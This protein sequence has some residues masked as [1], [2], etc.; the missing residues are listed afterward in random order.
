[1]QEV[2]GEEGQV[3]E[4]VSGFYFVPPFLVFNTNLTGTGK[5]ADCLKV[6]KAADGLE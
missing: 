3:E 4:T 2:L 5:L 1:M 6:N